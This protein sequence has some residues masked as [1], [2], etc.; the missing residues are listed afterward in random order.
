MNEMTVSQCINQMVN[1]LS[2][3]NVAKNL[4]KDEVVAAYGA[5][6]KR[7][8]ARDSNPPDLKILEKAAKAIFSD[9]T[10]ETVDQCVSLEDTISM[11]K[12]GE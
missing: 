9:K 1:A 11:F 10:M 12:N 7:A 8:W 2:R 6:I 4:Y 5:F 3:L